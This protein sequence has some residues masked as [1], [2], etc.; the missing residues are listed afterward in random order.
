MA[1]SPE[2]REDLVRDATAMTARAEWQVP[3]HSE[4]CVIGFRP[5]GAASIYFGEQPVLHFTAEGKIKRLFFDDHQW[6]ADS[7]GL[8][9]RERANNTYRME[10]RMVDLDPQWVQEKLT[11]LSE[12]TNRLLSAILNSTAICSRGTIPESEMVKK[13]ETLRQQAIPLTLDRP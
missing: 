11:E 3:G 5:T 8:K 9:R 12:Q 10:G 7:D 2:R 4:P 1:R 6:I 13:I